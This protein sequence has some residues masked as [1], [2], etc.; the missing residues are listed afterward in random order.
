MRPVYLTPSLGL[1]PSGALCGPRHSWEKR[2]AARREA[3]PPPTPLPTS[4]PR[5]ILKQLSPQEPKFQSGTTHPH[6][7]SRPGQD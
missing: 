2:V 4:L 6:P 3:P 7:R 5:R 1:W